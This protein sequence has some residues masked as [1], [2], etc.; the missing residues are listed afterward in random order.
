MGMELETDN[1]DDITA[2][3]PGIDAVVNCHPGLLNLIKAT[4][5]Y[6]EA[7]LQRNLHP[8]AG[9]I[10]PYGAGPTKVI[11][12]IPQGSEVFKHYGDVWFTSRT[13]KF[14]MLPLPDDYVSILK[15]VTSMKSMI[16]GLQSNNVPS[17]AVYDEL[18]LEIKDIWDSRT[19]NALHNF[20][21]DH[22]LQAIES[23]DMGIL[24]QPN[25]TRSLEWLDTYGKCIDHI[26][27]GPS[28][29]EGA[30]RGAFAKRDLP[31]GT[32]VSGTPLILLPFRNIT[33][34][35]ELEEIRE[36]RTIPKVEAGPIG[37]QILLNYCFGHPQSTILLCPYGAGVNYINHNRTQA[38]IKVQWS[39]HGIINHN[40]T[41]LD[42]TPDA[43]LWEYGTHLA[44]DYIAIQDIKKG[45]ELFLDYGH[46]WEEAWNAHVEAWK[47]VDER[48]DYISASQFNSQY[49][50]SVLRT[51][52]EQKVNRYPE[53]L[54]ILC[55]SFLVDEE[56]DEDD[57]EKNLPQL[58]WRPDDKGYSCIITERDD[59]DNTYVVVIAFESEG[60]IYEQRVKGVPRQGINFFDNVYTTDLHLLDTFRYPLGIPDEIFPDK[61]KN[62][63][64]SS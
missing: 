30:G 24:V 59:D 61:W 6:D 39:Q 26:V 12:D 28:T 2:F 4:P 45:D 41:W 9:A 14:G 54:L 13:Y 22:I 29:V 23:Q 27:P 31:K 49:G 55:H 7:G 33:T 5:T 56:F 35:Y 64:C 34:M 17:P 51:V 43:M 53:N 60:E 46:A 3:W 48:D 8:G 38:N 62:V 20:T 50:D 57:P 52:E 63:Q 19:L 10:T 11:R 58:E 18:I 36:G 21:W 37:Y 16:E 15:L 44:I 1:L 25:A 40:S 47:S 42:L 32:V